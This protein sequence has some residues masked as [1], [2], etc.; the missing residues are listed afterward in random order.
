MPLYIC[1]PTQ[2]ACELTALH[3][4]LLQSTSQPAAVNYQ[5]GPCD[6]RG[7]IA[8]EVES[9]LGDIFD[10]MFGDFMGGRGGRQRTRSGAEA[11]S[12]AA[13]EPSGSSRWET[14][15]SGCLGGRPAILWQC[16]P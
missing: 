13:A 6:K 4:L 1:A 11:P 3:S 14:K 7:L 5:C 12:N 16:D 2:D 8:G 10:Q 15:P 9:G